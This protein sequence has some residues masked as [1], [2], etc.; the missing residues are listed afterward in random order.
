MSTTQTDIPPLAQA[1]A[2]EPTPKIPVLGWYFRAFAHYADF[3]GRARR[4]EYWFFALTSSIVAFLAMMTHFKISYARAFGGGGGSGETACLCFYFTYILAALLPGLALTVRRLHDTG[5]SAW[6]LFFILIPAVGP[7][8]LFILL[9]FDG[10]KGA[11]KYGPDPKTESP[12][13]SSGTLFKSAAVV[14]FLAA[15][16]S[17]YLAWEEISRHDSLPILYF[18]SSG[19]AVLG[20]IT[21]AVLLLC[22]SKQEN[23][24]NA[25]V[26]LLAF[27]SF[28][29]VQNMERVFELPD[30]TPL[31]FNIPTIVFLSSNI[32]LFVFCAG[33]ILG[34]WKFAKI[35]AF[36]LIA[37]NAAAAISYIPLVSLVTHAT[38]TAAPI[39]LQ[40]A[41]ILL[42]CAVITVVRERKN[43]TGLEEKKESKTALVLRI[44]LS[45]AL[46]GLML[47]LR[48]EV[49]SLF[50]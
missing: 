19:M 49:I 7:V 11:N 47:L 29:A 3:S 32:L 26:F 36:I 35:M 33:V 43:Q 14:F 46:G 1:P 12:P 6:S 8:I 20:A 9:L 2:S 22:F 41:H 13:Q 45:L 31:Y 23:F 18:V 38:P 30:E 42:A 16:H 21:S 39:M 28:W 48:N 5:R 4:R 27:A 24:K 25:F 44:A 10:E 34:K 50:R 40:I 37:A 17:A 15:F